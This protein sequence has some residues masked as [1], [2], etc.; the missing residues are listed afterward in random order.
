MVN[1]LSWWL[2]P[3]ASLGAGAVE[4]EVIPAGF[5]GFACPEM[6][7]EA[8]LGSGKLDKLMNIGHLLVRL[9]GFHTLISL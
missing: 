6:M 7:G 5:W 8:K 2:N 9:V 4:A 1:C 3:T